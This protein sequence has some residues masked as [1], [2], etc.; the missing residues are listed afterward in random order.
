LGRIL[1]F[2]FSMLLFFGILAFWTD[3]LY[4]H[5]QEFLNYAWQFFI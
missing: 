5:G 2:T 3:I 1:F 4:V